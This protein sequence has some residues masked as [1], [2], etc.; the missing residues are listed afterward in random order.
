MREE[1][2]ENQGRDRTDP[3]ETVAGAHRLVAS[4]YM[5]TRLMYGS[6]RA[7]E[8]M[9]KQKDRWKLTR[10]GWRYYRCALVMLRK[11]MDEYERT[12][13]KE[14]WEQLKADLGNSDV[15]VHHTR[16]TKIQV[17][18]NDMIFFTRNTMSKLLGYVLEGCS[19]CDKNEKEIVKCKKRKVISGLLTFQLP[20][21]NGEGCFWSEYN[22]EGDDGVELVHRMGLKGLEEDR[23]RAEEAENG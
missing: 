21:F 13:P 16:F 4:E 17:D 11:A 6:F 18:D 3:A 2:T 12:L 22:L 9:A 23:K 15:F 5:D 19:L 7:L 20:V 14:G 10:N 1:Q 8:R